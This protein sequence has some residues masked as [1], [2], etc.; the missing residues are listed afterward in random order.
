MYQYSYNRYTSSVTTHVM[1][2]HVI[3]LVSAV[4]NT[5]YNPTQTY[6]LLELY[7]DTRCHR[8]STSSLCSYAH[9]LFMG[10]CY[11]LPC[12]MCVL[13]RLLRNMSLPETLYP[14][15]LSTH[16]LCYVMLCY[17]MLCYVMLCYVSLFFNTENF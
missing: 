13:K 9:I 5:T 7:L 6:L 8:Y 4:T 17:V 14:V 10:I 1:S 11:Y 2:C 12:K 3:A 15:Y 16:I